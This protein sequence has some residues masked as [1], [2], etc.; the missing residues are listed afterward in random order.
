LELA[1]VDDGTARVR[2]LDA[3]TAAGGTVTSADVVARTGL[4]P[5]EAERLLNKLVAQYQSDLDVDEDGTLLYRFDPA[6]A[7]RP[8]IVAAD[9][10]RRRRAAL[11]RALRKAFQVWTVAMV[12][13]YTIVFAVLLIVAASRGGGNMNLDG[14]G[15]SRS[16][17]RHG[18][19]NGW[20]WFLIGHNLSYSSVRRQRDFSRKV[21][22]DIAR[23]NDPYRLDQGE[24]AEEAK[25]GVLD[26]VWFFL[27]G[28]RGIERNPLEQEKELITYVRAKK[29]L[30]TNADLIALLG[31]TYDEADRI[32]TRLVATYGGE[33]EL[34][35]EGIAVYRFPNLMA[36][37]APE[38]LQQVPDLGYLWQVRRKEHALR[39]HPSRVIPALNAFNLVLSVVAPL[40]L[41]PSLGIEGWLP[42]ILLGGLP[43]VFS[44]IFFAVAAVR[45]LRDLRNRARYERDNIRIALYRLLFTRRRPVLLP[46][47]GA[48]LA[49]AGLG[50]WSDAELLAQAGPI[51]ADLRGEATQRA[52]GRTEIRA[53][54]VLR[55]MTVVEGLRAR[56]SNLRPVGRSVFSTDAEDL[57]TPIAEDALAREIAEL[58]GA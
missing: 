40:V 29:G 15:N 39:S 38:V 21:D 10:K 12:I 32:G 51:A 4:P 55:E 1:Q 31:C 28:A 34:T 24:A 47:D 57:R 45:I 36:S 52:D 41:L 16:R 53:Q 9:R 56:A 42:M 26:R 27:F 8:D 46:G 30:I 37:A 18:S 49:A 58:E 50:R 6:L 43:L 54:R 13:I 3:I 25:P 23:G 20:L 7:A 33:L 48:A 35:D 17:R 14:R 19:G 22:A 5:H 2:I 11:K 44:L